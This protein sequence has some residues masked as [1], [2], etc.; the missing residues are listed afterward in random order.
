[1][2]QSLTAIGGAASPG[3]VPITPPSSPGQ[4]NGVAQ[5]PLRNVAAVAPVD[6]SDFVRMT[7]PV[8]ASITS[9]ITDDIHTTLQL[10]STATGAVS[11]VAE[12]PDNPAYPLF[13]NPKT[14]LPA[15]QMVVDA[16]GI[17]YAITLS[18]LSVMP[19]TPPPRRRCLPPAVR[20]R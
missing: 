7:T 8:R 9:T 6:Q 11:T 20:R 5:S 18:G 13:G 17:A 14:P 2:N 12:M 1:M 16:N 15:R 10:V 4:T 3:Q 19:T